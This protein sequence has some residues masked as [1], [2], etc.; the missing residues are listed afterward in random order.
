[1]P[2]IKPTRSELIVL[3]RKIKLAQSGHRLLKKKRDG[4]VIEFF[5]VLKKAKDQ[6]K[7][8]NDAYLAAD[9]AMKKTIAFEGFI[10]IKN[11][12]T[13]M[14]EHPLIHLEVKNI[15]GVTVP[16]IDP[17]KIQQAFLEQTPISMSMRIEK[18]AETYTRLL[19]LIANTAE[20]ETTLRKIL[21]EIEK[22]KRRVNALEFVVIP[23]MQDQAAFIRMRLEEMERETIFRMKRIK[24]A[25]LT[26]NGGLI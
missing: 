18:L 26:K 21:K 10:S 24:K 4:L 17:I 5:T 12:A 16:K 3:K 2:D 25:A 19:E 14:T 22:T 9:D 15:M 23:R 11:T 13:V 6:R 20:T 7:E 8:L 1:M